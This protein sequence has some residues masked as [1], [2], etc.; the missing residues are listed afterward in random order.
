MIERCARQSKNGVSPRVV[1]ALVAL[2]LTL[3]WPTSPASGRDAPAPPPT[4]SVAGPGGSDYAYG[5]AARIRVGDEPTG[6]WVFSPEGIP[7]EDLARLPVVILLHGFGATDPQTYRGWIGHIVRRGATVIYPD[8][9][10]AGF[11]A[12]DQSA[13][14]AD[15]LAGVAEGLEAAGVEPENVHIVGHSLGAVIGTAYLGAGPVAGLP[16][17]AS[18]TLVAP[19]GCRTCGATPGFGV[20]LPDDLQPPDGLLVNIIVGADDEIVGDRDAREIWSRLGSVP[21]SDKRFV[22][23]QSDRHGSPGLIADH[24]FAQ[25]DGDGDGSAIDALDWY[26]VW[27]PL[28]SLIACA[29]TG[30]L[31]DVAL[32]TSDAALFMGEWSDGR[33]VPLPVVIDSP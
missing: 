30:R 17:A 24:L 33:A 27:R 9:Q 8:F 18:L 25:S 14:V 4:Q 6:A 10:P 12:P 22:E 21:A 19:G 13:F 5:S 11:L 31:C 26:G 28:D 20:A 32:G 29:D 15:M 1:L 16:P 3:A 7:A 2:I 23:V